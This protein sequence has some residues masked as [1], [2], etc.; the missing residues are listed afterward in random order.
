[1]ER[2]ARQH[3]A[4]AAEK[5][6]ERER[7]EELREQRRAEQELK[8]EK[9]RLTKER[10]HYLN[11]I[12]KLRDSGDDDKADELESQL[13]RIDEEIAQADY[14]AAYRSEVHTSELQSRFYLVCRCLLEIKIQSEKR[15]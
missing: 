3:E 9:E 8:A 2:A 5:M 1:S 11:S 14:R 13:A 7:K 12:R 10:T 4:G 6:L 15:I